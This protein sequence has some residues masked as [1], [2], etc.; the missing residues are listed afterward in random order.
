M[1]VCAVVSK[2]TYEI[3][4]LYTNGVEGARGILLIARPIPRRHVLYKYPMSS[5]L[6]C[7]FLREI[8][9]DLSPVKESKTK[10][11]ISGFYYYYYDI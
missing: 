2:Y 4:F 11:S 8:A 9:T 7:T 1:C 3:I 5:V 10:Y 6:R